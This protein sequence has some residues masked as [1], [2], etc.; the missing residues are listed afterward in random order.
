MTG[1]LFTVAPKLTERQQL[2]Y[3][4]LAS[5]PGAALEVGAMVHRWNGCSYCTTDEPCRF[6][7]STGR[8]VL[9]ALRKK[10][11]L[12]RDRHHLYRRADTTAAAV[13]STTPGYDPATAPIPF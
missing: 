6:A 12:K 3:D 8:Q 11:L 13:E 10:G 2:V 4:E 9:E 1:Q 7:Y 5:Q